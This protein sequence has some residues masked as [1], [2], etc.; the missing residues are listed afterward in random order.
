MSLLHLAM[1]WVGIR[2]SWT[3]SRSLRLTPFYTP[4]ILHITGLWLSLSWV[5]DVFILIFEL[6]EEMERVCQCFAHIWIYY[7]TKFIKL[8]HKNQLKIVR[9][10]GLFEEF[11]LSFLGV[12]EPSRIILKIYKSILASSA[13][14]CYLIGSIFRIYDLY[15]YSSLAFWR[16]NLTF[17]SFFW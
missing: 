8:W 13:R 17:K 11:L 5:R 6:V 10:K 2:C 12:S 16:I 14:R 4:I 15:F 3:R 7:Y 1:H 9:R